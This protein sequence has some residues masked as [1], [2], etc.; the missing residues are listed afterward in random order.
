MFGKFLPQKTIFFDFFEQHVKLTQQAAQL[1]Q[2]W[3]LSD[4]I[5]IP[6]G[7]N[8]IKSLEHQADEITSD[9]IDTLHNSFITPL[10]H[11][12]IFRL[13]SR[14]DDV[15]DCIDEIF[16]HCLIYKIAFITPAAKEMSQIGYY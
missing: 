13:I 16:D 8:P 14:L 2:Q 3:M 1:L 9:C 15:M 5:I 12:D 10:Q 6:E 11:N 7:I 4:Q